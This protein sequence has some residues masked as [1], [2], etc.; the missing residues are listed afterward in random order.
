VTAW[1]IDP[2]GAALRGENPMVLHRMRAGFAVFGD[3]QF[4]PGYALLFT[5]TPGTDH[6]TDLPRPRR[7]EYLAD[8]GLLG[9]AVARVCGARDPGLRRLNYET[10]GNSLPVLHTHVFPRYDWEPPEYLAGPV[11]DYPADQ[12]KHPVSAVGP[13]HDQLRAELAAALREITAV[14]YG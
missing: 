14:A 1:H 3:T 13:E 6:L 12:R 10:L 9:E 7:A 4:L 11:W 8:V 2:V 5:D